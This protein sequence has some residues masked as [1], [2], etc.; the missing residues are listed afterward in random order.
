MWSMYERAMYKNMLR[1]CLFQGLIKIFLFLWAW[2]T[3]NNILGGAL[4]LGLCNYNCSCRQ[5]ELRHRD[6]MFNKKHNDLLMPLGDWSML[7]IQ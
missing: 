5:P 2:Y 3:S 7:A 1:N 4:G 6:E